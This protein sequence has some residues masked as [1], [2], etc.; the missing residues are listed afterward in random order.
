MK[1][2]LIM[3]PVICL[4]VPSCS[5]AAYKDIENGE[6]VTTNSSLR[7]KSENS[8]RTAKAKDGQTDIS[9]NRDKC[10]DYTNGQD[11]QIGPKG[12]YITA[13][14]FLKDRGVRDPR[15]EVTSQ[16][17]R[18]YKYSIPRKPDARMKLPQGTYN[19][20]VFYTWSGWGGDQS[21]KRISFKIIW[22]QN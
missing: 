6:F 22:K 4:I 8:K 3:T 9:C 7:S 13:G 1:L 12:G 5:D 2:P 16:T 10:G 18:V 19:I 15:V 21:A 11:F 17:G 14:L 20:D